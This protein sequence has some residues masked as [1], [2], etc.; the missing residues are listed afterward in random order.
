MPNKYLAVFACG[1]AS[2]AGFAQSPDP[3]A[4]DLRA[5][6]RQQTA[7]SQMAQPRQL[8]EQQRAE[9]R[10]QL[11]QYSRMSVKGS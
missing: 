2:A 3:R 5:V 8:S 4:S 7:A 9:L 1:L 11:S 6:L 10:R